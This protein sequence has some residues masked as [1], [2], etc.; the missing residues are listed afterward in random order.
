[1]KSVCVKM[2]VIDIDDELRA[3]TQQIMVYISVGNKE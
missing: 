1:M 2:F 3:H